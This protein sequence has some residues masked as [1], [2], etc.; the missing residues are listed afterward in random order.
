[1]AM[2]KCYQ[3]MIEQ[4]FHPWVGL[5]HGPPMIIDLEDRIVVK[6]ITLLVFFLNQP[7]NSQESWAEVR[8]RQLSQSDNQQITPSTTLNTKTTFSVQ[9]LPQAQKTSKWESNI[10]TIWYLNTS[11]QSQWSRAVHCSTTCQPKK[12]PWISS[13]EYTNYALLGSTIRCNIDSIWELSR[14]NH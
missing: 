2:G 14:P 5:K 3:R 11:E 8:S 10:T 4:G 1:M 12:L 9:V 7:S 13:P 6:I